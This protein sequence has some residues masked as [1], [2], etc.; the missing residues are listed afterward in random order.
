MA[1]DHGMAIKIKREIMAVKTRLTQ[2]DFEAILSGYNLGKYI[3]W[4]A[5]N[6]G[7]V[8]TNYF[9]ETPLLG[10]DLPAKN[11]SVVFE[12]KE[13][14]FSLQKNLISYSIPAV[15]K[16]A[17]VEIYFSIT[18][19]ISVKTE[20]QRV[21][22]EKDRFPGDT[23]N[24]M[25]FLDLKGLLPED[26]LTKV[27]RMSMLN[28]LEVRV[29]FLDYTLVEFVFQLRGDMKIKG[30][31]RKYILMEAFKDLLPSIQLL[32]LLSSFPMFQ[33]V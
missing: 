10:A 25:L 15:K 31:S 16:E 7:T 4:E 21:E 14:K 27:D 28:S 24:L 29:P 11:V 12:N 8:Q 30:R 33:L 5:I 2:H 3:R 32:L 20:L 19:P 6:Q 26:M 9:L 22:E 23:V 18:N 13:L 17:I 1:V